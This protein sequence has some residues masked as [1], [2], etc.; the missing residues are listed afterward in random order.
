MKIFLK[1]INK[2][3]P[4]E[5]YKIYFY[6]K[7]KHKSNENDEKGRKEYDYECCRV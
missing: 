3:F 5:F 7:Y 1:K 2:N 6:N 4:V